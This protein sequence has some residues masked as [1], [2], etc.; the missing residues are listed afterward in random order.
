MPMMGGSGRA[1][2]VGDG[3]PDDIDNVDGGDHAEMKGLDRLREVDAGGELVGCCPS[4]LVGGDRRN[5]GA[6]FAGCAYE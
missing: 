5:R 3:V 4:G 2:V 6:N 1:P